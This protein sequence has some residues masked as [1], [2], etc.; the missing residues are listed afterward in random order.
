M[1]RAQ[2]FTPRKSKN[3]KGGNQWN[4]ARIVVKDG[5][6]EHWLNHTKVVEYDRFSQVFLALIEKSKY[7]NYEDFGRLTEG[8]ILLQDHGDAV[9]FRNIKIREF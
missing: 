8:H 9:S 3:F 4:N 1:I 7:E 6:V 2:S 5:K